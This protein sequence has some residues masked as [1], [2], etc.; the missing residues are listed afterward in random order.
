MLL[1]TAVAVNYTTTFI[2]Q[3]VLHK[4]ILHDICDGLEKNP[5]FLI[6]S[7]ILY[8]VQ[9]TDVSITEMVFFFYPR[10]KF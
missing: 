8:V 5:S 1:Y 2:T 4:V 10:I 3:K 9:A 6:Y 7:N